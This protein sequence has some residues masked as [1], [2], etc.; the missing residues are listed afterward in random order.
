MALATR[1]KTNWRGGFFCS[2]KVSNLS[3]GSHFGRSPSDNPSRHLGND[4]LIQKLDLLT[5]NMLVRYF[6]KW[7]H[8]LNNGSATER[9]KEYQLDFSFF[10]IPQKDGVQC[11]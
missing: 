10:T 9:L 11:L 8:Q 1:K 5:L 6:L 4:L 7:S 3:I 2:G